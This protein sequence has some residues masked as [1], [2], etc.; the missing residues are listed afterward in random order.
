[1][2]PS[3]LMTDVDYALEQLG[4]DYV[5]IIVLCR[6]NPA[7]PIEDSIKAMND[8]VCSGKAKYMGISEGSAETLRRACTV[9]PIYCIEQEWSLWTRDIEKD[10]VPFCQQRGILIIAYSP[11][12]RGFLTNTIASYASL[13]HTDYR[14]YG[15]PRFSATNFDLNLVM[16]QQAEA[17]AKAKGITM[18]QLALAFLHAQG[19]HVIPIP[20]TSSMEHLEKNIAARDVVLSEEELNQLKD[21]FAS[22][23][24]VGDRY[25]HMNMTYHGQISGNN[26]TKGHT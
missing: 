17:L 5:D 11:L 23:K 16:V 7:I 1:M 13:D 25:A 4:T 3:D 9:A 20:G 21:I 26:Q 15:Q 6:V 24:V 2:S 12:G 18:S 22:E 10:I 19:N 8:I 14:K